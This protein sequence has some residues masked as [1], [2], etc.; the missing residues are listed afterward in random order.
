M[1]LILQAFE[2]YTTYKDYS[3]PI[4]LLDHFKICST[5]ENFVTKMNYYE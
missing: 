3:W 4:P 2:S 5:L 1:I